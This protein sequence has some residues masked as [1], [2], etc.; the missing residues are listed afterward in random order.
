MVFSMSAFSSSFEKHDF[1][2]WTLVTGVES[3][4]LKD[5][6]ES[7]PLVS[8]IEIWFFEDRDNSAKEM[9]IKTSE[10]ERIENSRYFELSNAKIGLETIEISYIMANTNNIS[11]IAIKIWFF[12]DIRKSDVGKT[13]KTAAS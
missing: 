6:Q 3:L 11:N 1:S 4:P 8:D 10:C 13:T 5:L 2:I 12:E 9:T 7:I